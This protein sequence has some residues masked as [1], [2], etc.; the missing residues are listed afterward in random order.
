M[1]IEGAMR[2]LDV[3]DNVGLN[4]TGSY[5]NIEEKESLKIIEVEG[6]KIAVLSYITS[7]NY[8]KPE[9]FGDDLLYISSLMPKEANP[10]YDKLMKE[11]E[12]DFE[13]AKN[14]K[15]DL[16]MVMPHMGTQFK[17]T[18]N[19]FQ[20]KF[21][22]LFSDLG[23]DIVL[24][25]HALAVQPIEYINDTLIIN[26]PGNFAN[27][28]IEKNGDAPAIV[29]IYIDH[30]SKKVNATSVIPMYTQE[31][32]NRNFRAVPIYK[33]V[34]DDDLFFTLNSSEQSRMFEVQKLVS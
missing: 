15:V 24:G 13:Q 25:D 26:C 8:Y 6:I 17:H 4:H 20:K 18:T 7:T 10:Y 19:A 1:G 2:T 28:Y 32:E 3:L 29:K 33:F 22:Q 12:K 9:R 5:R 16:I 14:S 21:N 30:K 31:F 34:T 27:S 11:I 23:A